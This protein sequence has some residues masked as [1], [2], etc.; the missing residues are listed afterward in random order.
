[1]EEWTQQGIFLLNSAL[2]V[3]SHQ[4]ASHSSCGWQTFTNQVIKTLSE[5]KSGLVFLLLG[6]FA[7]KKIDLIDQSKHFVLQAAHPSLNNLFCF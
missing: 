4:P 6:G 1:M 5:N 2:T 3:R 7:Q